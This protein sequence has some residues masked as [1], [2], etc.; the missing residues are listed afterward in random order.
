MTFAV[1]A[2]G[3]AAPWSGKWIQATGC[4]N[5][6]NTWQM[7]RKDAHLASVPSKCV[8]RIA[9]DTKYWLWVNGR[10]VA[11][12]GGLKRGPSPTGTYYDEVDLARYLQKGDNAIA[13]LTVFFGKEGF[14]HK[15]SGTAAL[16][17][18]A[19]ADGVSLSSDES[20]EAQ[21]YE[22]FTTAPD[23]AP[24]YRLAESAIRFDGRKA[25]AGWHSPD[26]DGHFGAAKVVNAEAV[27]NVFGELVARPIPQW[28]D[29]GLK[30]YKN[31]SFDSSSRVLTCTLPYN[32]QVTPYIKLKATEAG[33]VIS[34]YTDHFNPSGDATVHGEYVTTTGEQ[35]YENLG[36]MNGD[37]VYYTIPE[38]VEVDEV[39][40]RETGYD[41]EL[42][43]SFS[44]DDPF[45]NKLWQRSVRTLYVNMRDT[46]FDC[47]DRERAQWWGDVVN[48]IQEAAYT[49]SPSASLLA[50]KGVFELMNWQRD[51]GTIFAPVPAGN[52]DKELP[53]Q[54]LMSVGWFG[55]YNQYYLNNDTSFIAH[56][57]DGVHR[58]LHEVW[59][60]D[61]QGF[62]AVRKGGW[63][64]GDWGSHIDMDLL[65]N[66]WY[67]LALK[68]E[69]Q[70]ALMLRKETDAADIA[71]MMAN[72]E[73]HFEERYWKG[74]YYAAPS[75]DDAADDRANAMA[76]VAG[77]ASPSH[78]DA[79][80]NVLKDHHYASPLLELY[81]QK[82]LFMLDEGKYAL[83]RMREQYQNMLGN[84]EETTLWEGWNDG[85]HNHAWASGMTVIFAESVCGIKPTSPGF[86]TVE[87]KPDLC[88]LKDVDYS[89]ETQHGFISIHLADHNG[90]LTMDLSV[91]EGTQAHVVLGGIDRT[92]AAGKHHFETEGTRQYKMEGDGLIQSANQLS[93]NCT[94]SE[95][96]NLANLIDGSDQTY[97]H[98]IPWSMDLTQQDEY[99]QVDLNRQDVSQFFMQ[100]NRR[101]DHT[102]G[103]LNHGETPKLIEVKAT[104]DINGQWDS[105]ATI[106]GFPGK[107]DDTWPFT[108]SMVTMPQPYRYLRLYCRQATNTYWTF[109]ELQLFS[110]A[111][112]DE[113][114]L[115][116]TGDGLIQ[117]A[118]QL[119][120]NCT[121]SE[122]G[123]L[124]N[125][126]DGTNQTY[127]HS[128][129]WSMDLTQQDEYIQVDLN[130]QDIQQCV[131]VM[132]RRFDIDDKG[133]RNFGETPRKLEIYGSDET[134]GQYSLVST[135][136]QF[137][138]K[139][140]GSRWPF[141]SP[142]IRM[143]KP[144]RFLRLYCRQATNTYWT[145]S[146]LQ[147][148]EARET[149]IPYT[150]LNSDA[151][152]NIEYKNKDRI[153]DL[154]GRCVDI[155]VK[156]RT[157][158]KDGSWNLVSLPFTIT[159]EE[160]DST[161]LSNGDLRTLEES[162]VIGDTLALQFSMASVDSLQAGK[163][164]LVR[165]AQG[166][167]V[168]DPTFLARTV[169]DTLQAASTKDVDFLANYGSVSADAA[170][171]SCLFI[172]DDMTIANLP[173]NG[174]LDSFRG[175]LRLK[176]AQT[177]DL[178]EHVVLFDD[179]TN[180]IS[181]LTWQDGATGTYDLSGC[182]ISGKQLRTGIF[183]RNG[184][185]YA[186][187]QV[188][189]L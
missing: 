161:P 109:S 139:N 59:K 96:G 108:S 80:L 40:Y 85:T 110:G 127:W 114:R 18:D 64:W 34:I 67:Y 87:V 27:N 3:R 47:P 95:Q 172:H 21:V 143:D 187:K 102:G 49:L 103:W 56:V 98:S 144:Y 91:P 185:K 22:A 57:Y 62:V 122:Q 150:L 71:A 82:A 14:S 106:T 104:N 138:D 157:L 7:F 148:Y 39:K 154:N 6:A 153:S 25:V 111:L 4:K 74:S 79:V 175:Y 158:K 42:S 169:T 178:V 2:S 141:T 54:M 133:Y 8:A 105:V 32:A 100:I 26:F 126:I 86:K 77:L 166:E 174:L 13:L 88:G 132:D 44:C 135:I 97:W 63:S 173:D 66:V 142:L 155:L 180:G 37:K 113:R 182:K 12:E 45:F 140:D 52:W 160:L 41:T 167:D 147:L 11:F 51:D 119:S 24:N 170:M 124:A 72:M 58:Y 78:H 130:R 84:S 165:W 128:I 181:T 35:A 16:L 46:Y 107:D 68:A 156:G 179:V 31:V 116:T 129:P 125:L 38:G 29:Y 43:S 171:D 189:S 112:D 73:Q 136:D 151:D 83:Q 134:D 9:V 163:P 131:F 186:A 183:I 20:W 90:V 94:W 92:C 65:T 99:I 176:T 81:V 75:Y 10:Q 89:F 28:K 177:T 115:V 137:P 146:E 145:F 17:F 5:E 55:F 188:K 149:A 184:K 19:E 164:Y 60:T 1:S 23:N 61:E 36:W 123:N 162:K 93:S 117:S 69:R 152:G 30:D 101:N 50:R 33:K 48:D 15:N 121:W 53:V 168:V 120:S 76:V 118:E 159:K 70:Y